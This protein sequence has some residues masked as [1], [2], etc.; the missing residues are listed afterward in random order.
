MW[1]INERMAGREGMDLPSPTLEWLDD[2]V[3]VLL[4]DKER[5]EEEED[6]APPADGLDDMIR[7]F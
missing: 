7:G 2:L 4:L 3:A 1:S 6:A 5:E